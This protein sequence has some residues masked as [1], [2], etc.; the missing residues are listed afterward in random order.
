MLWLSLLAGCSAPLVAAHTG[1]RTEALPMPEG[2]L[3]EVSLSGMV[4]YR[5]QS[6]ATSLGGGGALGVRFRLSDAVSLQGSAGG[7]WPDLGFISMLALIS[8]PA[9]ESAPIHGAIRT[10]F[11]FTLHRTAL[12][13]DW[14]LPSLLVGGTLHGRISEGFRW[15]IA[16]HVEGFPGWYLQGGGSTGPAFRF[17]VRRG[18]LQPFLMAEGT[19]VGCLVGACDGWSPG[20]RLTFGFANRRGG[21]STPPQPPTTPP[22]ARARWDR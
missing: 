5:Q 16:A 18:R 21:G 22:T 2:S 15:T 20:G 17:P 10:G 8:L 9:D 13:E 11:G 4:D 7:G 14:E 12:D 1:L 3:P 19:F 6:A